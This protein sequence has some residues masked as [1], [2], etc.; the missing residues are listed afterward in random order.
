VGS[1]VTW[2]GNVASN[3][4]GWDSL[5]NAI[6]DHRA[7]DG[8]AFD[9]YYYG[10]FSPA[11][12]VQA[13][14]G[15]GC[16]AGLGFVGGSGDDYVRA[17]IG[18]GFGG[19]MSTSTAVHEVGHNHGRDHA[20]CGT[21][22]DPAFPHPGAQ[23][24]EWGH[25]RSTGQLKAPDAFVD[26]MSYCEPAWISDYTYS[27]LLDRIQAVHGMD[28]FIPE[29]R[30]FRTYER[31]SVGADGATWLPQ[32]TIERPPIGARRTLQVTGDDGVTR[33]RDAAYFPY[34]HVEGGLY[35]FEVAPESARRVEIGLH[36]RTIEVAR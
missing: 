23:I 3:G 27:A 17:A 15:G 24:G 5:L 33:P 25:D 19:E 7:S 30:L 29:E 13:Y 34:D 22:G 11:A 8:A 32:T 31:I 21:S 4:S 2:N 36:Q 16:V 6:A 26:F 28:M 20:P 35:V 14:C 10:I 18:L 1:P 12:S 9:E